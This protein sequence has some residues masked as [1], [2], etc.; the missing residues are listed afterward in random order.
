MSDHPTILDYGERGQVRVLPTAEALAHDAADLFTHL[1]IEA[2]TVRG[3]MGVA[4]SGGT[5]PRRMGQLLAESPARDRVPWNRIEVFWGDERWVPLESDES[6]AGSAKRAFLDRVPIAA[7]RVHPFPVDAADPT[8]AAAAYADTI[9]NVLGEG[10]T[11]PRFDL[12]LLGMGDDG[13]TASLFPGTT[14]L[15][16]R[17]SLAVANRVPHL[18]TTRLSLTVP[19]LAAGREIVFLVGGAAK[20]QVLAAVLEGPETPDRLP[21]QL[22]R[23]V[24]GRLLWLVDEDAAARL[25]GSPKPHG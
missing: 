21:A 13:H 24:D 12:V 25:S 10:E 22:I 15:Q 23:P 14:A 4:L 18:T 9:R 11:T 8:A 2:V 17:D 20:A 6:N 5:T 19:V 3:Q 1:A 16:E 7:E